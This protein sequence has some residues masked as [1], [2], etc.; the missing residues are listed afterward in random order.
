MKKRHLKKD[1]QRRL[2]YK[3]LEIERLKYIMIKNNNILP[4][5]TRILANDKLSEL[6][7]K[8]T[9]IRNRCVL[10]GRSRGI[11]K[12]WQISRVKF[13]LLADQGLIPGVRRAS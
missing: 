7:G 3:N 13:K 6:K 9:E 11:I 8:R 5:K 4:L 2:N 1:Y 12:E 10:T